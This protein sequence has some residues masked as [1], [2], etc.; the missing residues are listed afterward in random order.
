MV[1]F[2]GIAGYERGIVYS[3]LCRS[4][5][6]LLNDEFEEKIRSFD[7][8]LFENPGTIGACTFIS[9]LGGEAVGMASWDPRQGPEVGIIGYNCI[10]P[11]YQGRGF[12]TAQIKEILRRLETD[13][14]KKV[15]VRTSEHPFFESAQKMYL[16]CGFREIKRY[17]T[18]DQSGYGTIEYEIELS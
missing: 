2:T 1:E 13:G 16:A 15:I 7:K 5:A 8:E 3:L 6:E 11:E 4:F 18:G 12:G 10:L 17:E 9:T 14:F